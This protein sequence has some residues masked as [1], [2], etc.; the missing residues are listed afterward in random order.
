M[1]MQLIAISSGNVYADC[2]PHTNV[3]A[4]TKLY[5]EIKEQLS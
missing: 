1:R 3:K 4:V 5:K 2:W